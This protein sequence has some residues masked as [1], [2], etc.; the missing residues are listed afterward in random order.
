[1]MG[2]P[3]TCAEW[4]AAR[5]GAMI[6]NRK[7]LDLARRI[8]GRTRLAIFTNN[9][10]LLKF[11]FHELFPE[12][13]AI[14]SE[15]YCSYEFAAK[16]PDP[17]SFLR[18]VQKLGVPP[19]DAWFIDDKPSNVEGARRAGLAGHH[20]RSHDLLAEDARAMGLIE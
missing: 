3:I 4:I 11:H 5:R 6:P 15:R 2:H 16:K 20:F 18:L 10:P 19:Q 14:F 12:A 7:V 1:R 8:G 17:N 9:G 13:A